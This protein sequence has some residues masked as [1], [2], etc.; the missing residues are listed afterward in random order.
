MKTLKETIRLNG[1]GRNVVLCLLMALVASVGFTACSEDSDPA[2][3]PIFPFPSPLASSM[4]GTD[5]TNRNVLPD[6]T[7]YFIGYDTMGTGISI[8][9][10]LRE[11]TLLFK[12]SVNLEIQNKVSN[13]DSVVAIDIINFRYTFDRYAKKGQIRAT[14]TGGLTTHFYIYTE[15]SSGR[16]KLVCSDLGNE[17]EQLTK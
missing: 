5:W 11:Y 13:E 1:K 7:S 15:N 16:T 9:I 4:V 2:P 8:G 12:D 6:G 14:T 10:K 17:F 3:L